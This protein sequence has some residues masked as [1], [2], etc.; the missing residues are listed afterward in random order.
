M[1]P[2]EA[3]SQLSQTLRG[4]NPQIAQ[5]TK[6]AHFALRNF[7]HED[8]LFPLIMNI[9]K[10]PEVELNQKNIVFQ[11]I[12]VLVNESCIYSAQ[13]KYAYPFV[14]N[15]RANL[16]TIVT[17]VVPHNANTNLY[18][19]FSVLE[20][21]ATVFK[22]DCLNYVQLFNSNLLEDSDFE[23]IKNDI[24]YPE[25]ELD[26]VDN[27]DL[28]ETAWKFLIQKKKQ[29]QYEWQR[30]LKNGEACDK[31]IDEDEMFDLKS[32]FD[33]NN[34]TGLLKKQVLNRM[35]DDRES[36]KR[37]K[38]LLWHVDRPKEVS[39]LLEDEFFQYYYSKIHKLED[40]QFGV[41]LDNLKDCNETAA[42]SYKDKQVVQDDATH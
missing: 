6:A 17:L 16:P 34:K 10:D 4:L 12:E 21:L 28:M 1:D 11:F 39:Y 14:D 32:K 25:V 26:E 9:L 7:I 15:V 20:S 3:A 30:R 2:F 35:E 42:R 31:N 36:H 13:G 19:V 41:L 33:T 40:K 5:I 24:P 23:N 38:E 18:N 22:S 27:S 37:L 29:S 8:Y